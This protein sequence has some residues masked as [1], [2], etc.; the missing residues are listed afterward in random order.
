MHGSLG[1][2][3][4][5]DST[6]TRIHVLIPGGL[7]DAS[8]VLRL[9]LCQVLEELSTDGYLLAYGAHLDHGL[10]VIELTHTTTIALVLPSSDKHLLALEGVEGPLVH[11]G[12]SS[13]TSL[14]LGVHVLGAKDLNVSSFLHKQTIGLL[15]CLVPEEH[16]ILVDVLDHTLATLVH[17]VDDLDYIVMVDGVSLGVDRLLLYLQVSHVEAL[18]HLISSNSA[19]GTFLID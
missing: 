2:T 11:S 10:S 12:H 5:I 1:T 9:Y 14:L 16:Y 8:V 15:E 17:T 3:A 4:F 7:P 19:H 13:S 18:A 6:A